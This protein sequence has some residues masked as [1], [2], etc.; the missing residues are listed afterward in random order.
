MQNYSPP[1]QVSPDGTLRVEFAVSTGLMSHE[2]YS[3]RVTALP[4]GEVLAD[5]WGT[6]WDA[7][8]SFAEA[9]TV[10]LALRHYPGDKPGF[11]V[12]IDARAR[13]FVFT[14]SPD[15]ERHALAHFKR[16]IERKLAAQQRYPSS[17]SDAPPPGMRAAL[18]LILYVVLVVAAVFVCAYVFG[19]HLF[20]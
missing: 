10:T 11:A 14:G 5:L 6:E 20:R 7:S 1:S 3:P 2:I 8:A 16:V 19:F 17:R 12:K 4:A 9:G 18:K 13:T 15:D